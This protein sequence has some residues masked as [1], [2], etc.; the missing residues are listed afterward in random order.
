M[1]R[2]DLEE[3]RRFLLDSLRDL[4]REHEAGDIAEDDYQLLRD[5]YTARAADVMR[6]LEAADEGRPEPPR[7]GP[8][9]SGSR[10][11]VAGVLLLGMVALA[12]GSVFL[13]AS[14]RQ[15]GDPITGSV[16]DTPAGRLDRAHQLEGQG[17][18]VEALKLY[19]AV[20][21]EDPQN[22][23]ALTYRG[24]LLKLAGLTDQAQAS[25]DQALR[26]NPA[27]PDAHFFKG[28]LLYQDRRDPAAAVVE[29]DAYLASNPPAETVEAVQ[30]VRER[31][32][33]EAEAATT[34]TTTTAPGGG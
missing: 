22:V 11:V 5:D 23:E 28:M 26:V 13:L 8:S 4:E 18:V 3:E 31:A 32:R 14:D 19:D 15:P 30:G 20:L 34:T 25:L 17:E 24:W 10:K 27:Y 21:R 6:A 7:A 1:S 12:G 33:A 16:P 9:R 2:A 29:F